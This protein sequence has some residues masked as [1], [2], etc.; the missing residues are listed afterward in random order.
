MKKI[1]V[2]GLGQFGYQIATTMSQKG[3]EVMALDKDIEI[4]SEIKELVAQS[5]IVDSTDEKAMRAIHVDNLDVAIVAIGSN[6]QSSLLTTALLQ[7]MNVGS[8]FVRSINPLQEQI[9]SSM[10]IKNMVNIEKEMGI[11]LANTLS[12]E[13]IDR[14]VEISDKHALM[15]ISVPKPLAGKKL[16]DLNLRKQY[17]INIV[18]IKSIS[19]KVDDLGDIQ[20]TI[21]MTD[22]PDPDYPLGKDDRLVI[23]GTDDNLRRFIRLGDVE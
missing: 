10:G 6:V 22:I 14:Y 19:P 3:F 1:A 16:R 5:I 18:G 9:L 23:A 13:S 20:Y 2:I 4:V 7:Q 11:Q 17:K 8:I 21:E 15:E 12:S